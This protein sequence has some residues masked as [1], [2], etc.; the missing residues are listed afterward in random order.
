MIPRFLFIPLLH[1]NIHEGIAMLYP[2]HGNKGFT[3]V[4]LMI[5]IGIIGIMA[6]IALPA[7]SNYM[8]RAQI[9]EAIQLAASMKPEVEMA[10][11]VT[12]KLPIEV[13]VSSKGGSAGR[14]VDMIEIDEN[15]VITATISSQAAVPI[16]NQQV[17]FTP[18][19]APSSPDFGKVG[20]TT[21]TCGGSMDSYFLPVSCK[22]D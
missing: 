21:W 3:L 16:Q 5:A 17:T 22:G 20:N 15:G 7:Y 4:E 12:G 11:A 14:Y 19:F 10:Y 2:T 1:K 9:S 18:S 6:M 8:A 13:A